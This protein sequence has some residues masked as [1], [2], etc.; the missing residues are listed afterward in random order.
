MR[1]PLVSPTKNP[2]RN[3]YKITN[4]TAKKIFNPLEVIF[5]L[6]GQKSLNSLTYMDA[7]ERPLNNKLRGT[8]VLWQI[9]IHSQRL[10]ARST[11]NDLSLVAVARCMMLKASM[12]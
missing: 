6:L 3:P 12:T 2:L 8:V 7:R 1:P 4:S 10:I 11:R 9:C 5:D